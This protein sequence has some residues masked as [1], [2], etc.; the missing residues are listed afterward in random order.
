MND[1]PKA[2]DPSEILERLEQ[3]EKE[4]QDRFKEETL[5]GIP[6]NTDRGA[7]SS[8][9]WPN[10][11]FNTMSTMNDFET[12]RADMELFINPN[13]DSLLDD[14]GDLHSVSSERVGFPSNN[15][16]PFD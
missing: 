6:H 13:I 11:A 10:S 2:P 12:F 7:S 5:K 15:D 8:S 9:Y 4:T 16:A 14:V 3:I 1:R